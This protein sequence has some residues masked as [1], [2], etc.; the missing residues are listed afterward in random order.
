MIS[1]MRILILIKYD[2]DDDAIAFD[3][4][5]DIT[6]KAIFLQRLPLHVCIIIMLTV[7]Y[8]NVGPQK[9]YITNL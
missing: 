8:S 1:M 4:N 9:I 3:D 7:I 2:T 5:A 6:K